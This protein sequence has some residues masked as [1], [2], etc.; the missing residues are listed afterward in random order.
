MSRSTTSSPAADDAARR[1][2]AALFAAEDRHFW[3]RARN[4]VIGAVVAELITPL[5]PG[6]HVLEVG[7]GNGNVLRVLEQA[8]A[9]GEV[10]GF[11]LFAERL[12]Y[13]RAR[14]KCRLVQ[15]DIHRLPFTTPFELIG[16]FDVLE[17]LPDD[18]R[19]LRD[20]HGAL[21]PEGRLLLTVPAHMSLWSYADVNA[22]HF[23]RY[24]AD[25]LAAVLRRTGFEVEYVSPFMMPLYPLMWLG[26]RLAAWR[27][28][29]GAST[30]ASDRE[31]FLRELRTVPILN[32]VLTW[33]LECE[34][35]WLRRRQSLPLGT[36][37]LA[38]GRRGKAAT[39]PV[40]A[41][42]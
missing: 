7:C 16:M 19:V 39:I 35:P 32:S 26:R 34:V 36:S 29:P 20:L 3:F 8:C 14:T 13:A 42:A 25:G 33:L 18:E 30:E 41:S 21:A 23:R 38:V 27:R 22:G 2:F 12:Q 10:T 24:S 17:H 5:P 28:R 6:Y 11:D 4:R 40:R 9:A 15:G 37:L 31:L 1:E